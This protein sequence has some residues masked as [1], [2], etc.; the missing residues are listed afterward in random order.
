MHS[1]EYHLDAPDASCSELIQL[2]RACEVRV[3]ALVK[4]IV[5][6]LEEVEILEARIRELEQTP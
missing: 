3:A 4:Q 5:E 1:Y 6:L 2:Q